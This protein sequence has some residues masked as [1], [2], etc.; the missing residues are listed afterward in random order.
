[1]STSFENINT[2]RQ[3]EL[4]NSVQKIMNT[5]DQK[6]NEIKQILKKYKANSNL[7]L[8]IMSVSANLNKYQFLELIKNIFLKLNYKLICNVKDSEFENLKKIVLYFVHFL[9]RI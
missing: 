8:I 3:S 7:P 2:L 6:K 5:Y 9:S 1:M 4:N